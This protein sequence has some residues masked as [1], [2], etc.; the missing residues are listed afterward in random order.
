[1]N[2]RLGVYRKLASVRSIEDVEGYVEE[3]RD[4]YGPL[5]Q[6]IHNLAEYARIRLAADRIGLESLDRQGTTVVLKFRQ[7]ARLDPAWLLRLVQTRGDLTLLPPAVL[8]L[9]LAGPAKAPRTGTGRPAAPL[10][11]RL[12]PRPGTLVDH[13]TT[14][15]WW[16]SRAKAGEVTTGFSR[17]AMTAEAKLD[18]AAQDGLF[19]RLGQLLGQLK[20]GLVA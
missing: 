5:P 1:M 10:P 20:Q 12:R 9:E 3:L 8:K 14:T 7:D 13:G 16:T 17:E 15:S 11:G 18:P 19:E 6:T 4:R 2:Q